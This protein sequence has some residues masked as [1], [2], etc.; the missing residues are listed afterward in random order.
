MTRIYAPK[1]EALLIDRDT[2][3]A[4]LGCS[5]RHV[6]A[7]EQAGKLRPIR[8]LTAVRHSRKF[9]DDFIYVEQ[10]RRPGDDGDLSFFL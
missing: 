7:L 3:A 8:L 1:A 2:V 4:L 9:I 5:H 6:V 10:L